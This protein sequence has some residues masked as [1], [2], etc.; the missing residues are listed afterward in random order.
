M[1]QWLVHL[2]IAQPG[3]TRGRLS[4]CLSSW[5]ISQLLATWGQIEEVEVSKLRASAARVV[6][7]GKGV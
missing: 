2:L 4:Y 6:E 1:F 5:T 7:T 3:E